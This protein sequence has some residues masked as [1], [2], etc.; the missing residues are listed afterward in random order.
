MKWQVVIAVVVIV[1]CVS[2]VVAWVPVSGPVAWRGEEPG[3]ITIQASGTLDEIAEQLRAQ[4]AVYVL[5][6]ASLRK[7]QVSLDLQNATPTEVVT[8]IC[9]QAGCVYKAWGPIWPSRP[10]FILREGDWDAD[11]RPQ[12]T[13]G[14]YRIYVEG[15]E[16]HQR[17]Q[18]GFRWGNAE[19]ARHESDLMT[20]SLLAEA[21][22]R[23]A[24]VRVFGL[25]GAASVLTDAG[26]MLERKGNE[27]SIVQEFTE[28]FP[29]GLSFPR[30]A[31]PA[32]AIK[33]F[34]GKLALYSKIT[35]VPCQFTP[36]EIGSTKPI[37]GGDCTLVDWRE[38]GEEI[39]IA[40]GRVRRETEGRDGRL[41][42][43]LKGPDGQLLDS[44][45]FSGTGEGTGA[46]T[47]R[48][49]KPEGWEPVVL[50]LD[51]YLRYEPIEYVEFCI[52]DI[53]LP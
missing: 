36:D 40:A 48:F 12:T 50:V 13:V 42:A 18:L 43:L 47:W 15:V 28:L 14:D 26:E 19:P 39:H 53:P 1:L 7:R 41:R 11:A 9:K 34:R 32:K 44:S 10:R 5:A 20:V 33:E 3:T 51:G 31:Q 49:R 22:D 6:D 37:S 24:A 45:R 4:D 27:R 23:E 38:E 16:F 30:P 35:R 25:S 21:A 52:R 8:A 46:T 2:G 17:S 29:V